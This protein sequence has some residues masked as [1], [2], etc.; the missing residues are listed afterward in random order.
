MN[1]H[2]V[3]RQAGLYRYVDN[4]VQCAD[5]YRV[6]AP[7]VL[8]N[9]RLFKAFSFNNSRPIQGLLPVN[10]SIAYSPTDTQEKKMHHFEAL[11]HD[12]Y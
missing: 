3:L 1:L 5:M 11:T 12:I 9:P 7:E 2:V 8:Q 10:Q 6:P 4:T